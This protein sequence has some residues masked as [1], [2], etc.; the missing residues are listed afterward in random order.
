M[1]LHTSISLKANRQDLISVT[2]NPISVVLS[3]FMSY[4]N[5]NAVLQVFV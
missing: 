2:I 3:K 4:A 5:F 1:M